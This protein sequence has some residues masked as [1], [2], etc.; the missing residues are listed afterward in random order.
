M[1]I[2]GFGDFKHAERPYKLNSGDVGLDIT[3]EVSKDIKTDAIETLKK[4]EESLKCA[5]EELIKMLNETKQ[6]S[7]KDLIKESIQKIESFEENIN[8][9][10]RQTEEPLFEKKVNGLDS[11]EDIIV[12]I[13]SIIKSYLKEEKDLTL[14]ETSM[15]KTD[16]L[17]KKTDAEF[18]KFFEEF[19][20]ERC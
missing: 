8:E 1:S 3:A 9:L 13:I 6:Q 2:Y 14:L 16:D 4:L 19:N 10:K 11:V 18:E 20:I 17:I 12:D 5:N 7:T 15:K